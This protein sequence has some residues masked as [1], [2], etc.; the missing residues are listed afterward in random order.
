[1]ASQATASR[2]PFA[3]VVF[4]ALF[5]LAPLPILVFEG[6]VPLARICLLAAVSV[7]VALREGAS[8]PVGMIVGLLVGHALVYLLLVFVAARLA[9]RGLRRLPQT[10]AIVL[11]GACV[12]AGAAVALVAQPYVTPFGLEPRAN[13]RQ[14][15]EV[16]W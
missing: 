11:L 2:F 16:G 1:M 6:S 14:A 10:P 13:L 15:L 3:T 12:A 4:A 7:A 9:A 5:L 8:G